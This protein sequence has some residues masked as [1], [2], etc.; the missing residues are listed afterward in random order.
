ML[1]S[2]VK[3]EETRNGD[4]QSLSSSLGP[5][6][7]PFLPPSYTHASF[8]SNICGVQHWM[9]LS[10]PGGSPMTRLSEIGSFERSPL[11]CLLPSSLPLHCPPPPPLTTLHPTY[12]PPPPRQQDQ[13]QALESAIKE[14][15]VASEAGLSKVRGADVTPPPAAPSL[16]LPPLPQPP[17]FLIPLHSSNLP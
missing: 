8:N 2:E 1:L 7:A 17:S 4:L 15:Q 14:K 10:G 3:S 13:R 5:Q 6:G 12:T 11:A 9:D 16:S